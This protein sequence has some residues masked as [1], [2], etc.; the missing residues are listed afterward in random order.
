MEI[1][2]KVATRKTGEKKPYQLGGRE[3]RVDRKR[4]VEVEA[5]PGLNISIIILELK[6][7]GRRDKDADDSST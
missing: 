5:G 6:R 7:L 3:G 2:D 1:V 4:V